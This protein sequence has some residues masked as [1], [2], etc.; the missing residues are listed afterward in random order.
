MNG[1]IIKNKVEVIV[2]REVELNGFQY[3]ID[4]LCRVRFSAYNGSEVA[5]TVEARIAYRE[6]QAETIAYIRENVKA[7]LKL[8]DEEL[9]ECSRTT[10]F[11]NEVLC[12]A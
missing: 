6:L 2:V 7:I 3:S 11:S 1:L 9:D 4:N 8:M 5:D 12:G 10:T